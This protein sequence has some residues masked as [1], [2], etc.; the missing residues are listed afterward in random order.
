M[1]IDKEI[2]KDILTKYENCRD[3]K[4]Y[5][6]ILSIIEK[7]NSTEELHTIDYR[8]MLSIYSNNKLYYFGISNLPISYTFTE[9]GD[10]YIVLENL[11]KCLTKLIETGYLNKLEGNT[12]SCSGKL[13]ESLVCP[14]CI[15]EAP[16]DDTFLESLNTLEKEKIKMINGG[17]LFGVSCNMKT[18]EVYHNY[19]LMFGKFDGYCYE[20]DDCDYFT[21]LYLSCDKCFEYSKR[22]SEILEEYNLGEFGIHI[23]NN[24]DIEYRDHEV[25]LCIDPDENNPL[26][27][28][29]HI[30]S[31]NNLLKLLEFIES[32]LP[33]SKETIIER[34]IG[35]NR[36]KR[37]SKI[38]L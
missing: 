7:Y 11:F 3:T 16:I 12:F 9:S 32:Y 19:T 33:I 1:I 4:L 14:Q 37:S 27:F 10:F 28:L 31:K 34:V 36:I 23:R 26:D 2:L 18:Y 30:C 25:N 38:E 29:W 8:D 13:P 35:V 17:N 21:F 15:N 6:I 24:N 20:H 22:L 5:E